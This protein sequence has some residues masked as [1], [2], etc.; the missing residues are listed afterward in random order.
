MQDHTHQG[1]TFFHPCAVKEAIVLYL[2]QKESQQMDFYSGYELWQKSYKQ[3][4][5]LPNNSFQVS[6]FFFKKN[7]AMS[8]FFYTRKIA[9]IWIWH[10]MHGESL[11]KILRMLFTSIQKVT[12]LI[13]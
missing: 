13:L 9:K 8:I 4:F 1:D 11:E 3:G 12:E 5:S 7:Y 6:F 2:K 10:H